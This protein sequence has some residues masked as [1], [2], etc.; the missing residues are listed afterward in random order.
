MYARHVKTCP[1]CAEEIQDAAIKCKHCGSILGGE[2]SPPVRVAASAPVVRTKSSGA[3]MKI[4][5]TI[6]CIIGV[7]L[8]AG[9]VGAVGVVLL[10]G[11]L[12][13]FVIGRFQDG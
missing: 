11:G 9:G 8:T 10:L 7:L 2:A 3:P 13:V 6:A 1:Y 4:V 5:G 12:V